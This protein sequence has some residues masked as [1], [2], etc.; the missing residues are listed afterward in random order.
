MLAVTATAILGVGSARPLAATTALAD[1]SQATVQTAINAAADGT[2]ITCPAGSW[3]WSG[4]SIVNRNITLQ[5]AG[6]DVT[7]ISI[8]AAGGFEARATNTKGFRVTGFT[9]TS[10]ANF[11]TDGGFGMMRIY[12]GHNWRIDHNKF[13]IYSNV[14][15]YDGGNGIYTVNDVSG[16]IDHNQFVKGGGSGCMHAAVYPEGTGNTARGW[17]TQIGSTAHTVFVEDNYFFNPDACGPHNAHAVYAQRGGIYVL[18]HN[19]IRGMNIDSHGFCATYGTREFEISNNTWIGVGTNSLFSVVH[20]RGGTG[21]VYG[22][23]WSGAITSAYWLEDYRAQRASGCGSTATSFVPGYGT[24]TANTSCPEGYPCAEQVGRGQNN[25]ADPLYIW[26]NTGVGSINNGAP[27]Y[28]QSGRDFILN[29]GAKPGY[30]SYPYPHPL[31]LSGTTP[32]PAP[33]TNVRIVR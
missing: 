7:K 26:G 9:F 18:R 30:T 24:V 22:N 15:S 33:P 23:S 12:G 2:V 20:L 25:N 28:I 21:V 27:S 14:V 5:G 3:S 17:A 16:V 29:Q 32:P 13:V 10:T 1:C 8:T 19:E 11:G 31:T 6:I 4:V